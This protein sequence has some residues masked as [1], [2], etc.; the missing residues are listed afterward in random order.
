[1]FLDDMKSRRDAFKQNAI[2]HIVDFAS[3]AQEA[4]A[5]LRANKYDAIYLDHDLEAEHYQTNEEYH[6]DGSFVARNLVDMNQHHGVI[7][8]VHSLNPSGRLNIRSILKESF[9]VWLP[10]NFRG[11]S[12]LWKIEVNVII[13]AIKKYNKQSKD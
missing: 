13:G 2:G 12:E 4:I 3:T 5:F 1:M 6:E 10:E 9:D 8:V 7:V 11:I